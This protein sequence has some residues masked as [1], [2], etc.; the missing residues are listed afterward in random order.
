MELLDFGF[1]VFYGLLFIAVA[2]AIVYPIITAIKTPA[3]LGKS[4]VGIGALVVLFGISYALSGTHLSVKSAAMGITE[5]SAKMIGA[6]LIMFYVA[7]G[8]SILVL[9]YAEISKALKYNGSIY[10]RNPKCIDGG[11]RLLATYIL[12]DHHDCGEC[13]GIVSSTST[14]S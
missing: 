6:G 1:Y 14:T 7:L 9:I 2:A 11:Y 12:L 13:E 4:A 10:P 8:F 5:S 3:S